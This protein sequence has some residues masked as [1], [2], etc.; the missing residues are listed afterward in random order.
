MLE[1][2]LYSTTSL[3][4]DPREGY[5]GKSRKMAQVY[6]AIPWWWCFR[7]GLECPRITSTD[8]DDLRFLAEWHE[9]KLQ[10]ASSQ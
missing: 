5:R 7:S 2:Y 10:Y 3:Q 9:V 6:P 4:A 8:L 1:H